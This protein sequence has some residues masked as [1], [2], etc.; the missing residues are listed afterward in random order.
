MVLTLIFIIM[1]SFTIQAVAQNKFAGKIF[2]SE[3]QEPLA[4]VNI[5]YNSKNQGTSTDL[6]GYF[7]IDDYSKIE[8]LKITYIGYSPKTITKTEL[9][10][11]HY[12]EIP[13][14]ADV[15]NL[16]EVTVLPGENPAHRIINKVIENADKNNPEK[17]RSFSYTSYNKM[18]FT[19]EVKP[20]PDSLQK[21]DTTDKQTLTEFFAKQHLLL[22]E[23]VSER[24]Y[25]YPDNNNEKVLAHRMSGMQNPAFTLLATQFQSMSFYKDYISLLDKRF[26]SPICKGSTNKYFFQI[27]DTMYNASM[28]TIFVISFR[29]SK[30]KVFDGLKGVM[31]INTNGYAVEN[32]TAEPAIPSEIF[33]VS[34]QQK[35]ELIDSVQWFPVQLNTNLIFNMLMVAEETSD[36]N[37]KP[38][39]TPIIG[40]SKSYISDINLNPDIKKRDFTN[41]EVKIEDKANKKNDDFWNQYR[42]DSL[43]SK[44]I[45]T[46]RVIDSLGKA[47]NLDK[48]I[49]LV[50]IL[51]T[52]Y[53]PWKIFNI[54]VNSIIWFNEYENVRL[55]LGVE[56]NE[57]LCKWMSVGGY[58]AY[59]FRDKAF[60]YGVKINFNI[61]PK[62][63][64][65]LS[66]AYKKDLVFSDEITYNKHRNLIS[67]QSINEWFTEEMDSISEHKISLDFIALK[68]LSGKIQYRHYEKTIINTER[69]DFFQEV[70]QNYM[71]SEVGIFLKY[72][73]KEK[74]FQTP[75]GTKIS[76]G[77]KYP[78]LFFNFIKS[79]PLSANANDY[80]K[81]EAQIYKHFIIRHLGETYLTL[82]GAMIGGTP[83]YSEMYYGS[84]SYS[85][86][87]INNT[88]N[89]MRP[90]EF[91][92]DRFAS[93][94]FRH[95]FGNILVKTKYFRPAIAITTSICWGDNKFT[96]D[97]EGSSYARKLNKGYFE[98]GIQLN[99]LIC[100]EPAGFGLGVYY[101]YGPYHFSKEIDNW[102]F[103]LT[104]TIVF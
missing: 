17:I 22:M 41:L 46:Y 20:I 40:I 89:T 56:T 38:N 16:S 53:I 15:T 51:A 21:N 37:T 19:A 60:K 55:G 39:Y 97:I 6:D 104:W 4:F 36:K 24:N 94:H 102:A 1:L 80:Y 50:E 66:L 59:G 29:P 70:P 35:Y 99:N 75:R 96:N 78:I 85:W 72:A 13:L 14:E 61:I 10:D 25:I 57:K 86:L 81:I 9:D 95:N 45:E 63:N 42:K 48:K 23:S 33:D 62:H 28:D 101:R 3:K 65:K 34:I 100:S 71:S 74:F 90:G 7:R 88:F 31:N 84:G 82:S 18:Y 47:V 54:D 76:L 32:I 26:L 93:F 103:K 98:S 30:G 68:Y 2:D 52:G 83:N 87:N 92:S 58:G 49:E 5:I 12:I 77:T 11:K 91:I 73:Y 69:Y 44:D 27:E 8:F 79:V 67:E 64:V 43:N